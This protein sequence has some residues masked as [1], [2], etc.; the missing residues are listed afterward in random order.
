[1]FPMRSCTM[2]TQFYQDILYSAEVFVG[3]KFDFLCTVGILAHCINLHE[4]G[5]TPW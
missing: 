5:I 2:H 1:M 4:K 3:E